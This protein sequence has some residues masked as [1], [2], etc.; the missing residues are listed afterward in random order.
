MAST[1]S[2]DIAKVAKVA[3]LQLVEDELKKLEKDLEGILEA[4]GDLDSAKADCE[5]SF[6][7]I[8]MKNVMREDHIEPS[9]SQDEALSNTCHKENGF[10]KGPRII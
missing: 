7:P 1:G 2:F 4:F 6:Q 9:L 3:R 8:P 5:P 10:F